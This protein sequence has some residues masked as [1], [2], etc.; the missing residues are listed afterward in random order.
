MKTVVENKGI[1][2]QCQIY[3]HKSGM[4]IYVCEKPEYSSAYA[5]FGTRYGSIDTKFRLGGD[6][7]FTE[8]PEGIAHYLEHKLFESEDGDAFSRYAKT[9]AMANAFTS[10]DRTC[11][12]FS[13]SSNFEDSFRIL[14]DFVQHPYFTEE[15]VR[16][17]QGIIGQEI[18]MYDDSAPWRVLFNLLC[19]L[20]HNHP[21]RIDIAGTIESIAQIN[22]DLLYQCYRTFYN[23][24]NM[25]IC[26]AG[27]V[28]ADEVFRLCDELLLDSEPVSIERATHAEPEEIVKKSVEIKLPVSMPLFAI[29]YKERC[30]KPQK[31]VKERV[32]TEILMKILFGSD[33]QLYKELLDAELINDKFEAEYFTGHG[34]AAVLVE[35]ESKDPQAV[36]EKINAAIADAKRNGVTKEQFDR[37][38]KAIY[39]ADAAAYNSVENI[40]MSMVNAAFLNEGVFDEIET[41]KSVT[42]EDVNQRLREILDPAHS[43]ISVVSGEE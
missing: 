9:G 7:A 13:C 35:G 6:A 22:A 20:Y 2:E 5:I 10:F 23:L 40:V 11:Y 29:G 19:A 38:R 42:L 4:N 43:A 18:Q 1:K 27:N 15:T 16:K 34:Y 41:V 28:K 31:T 30:E 37:A 17:E 33:S 36:Y 32:C 12:L 14:L 3:R 39:G 25:F 26:V 24:S 8:V 21:V